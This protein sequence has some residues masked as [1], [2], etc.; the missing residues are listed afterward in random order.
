MYYSISP[1][2]NW[3]SSISPT[4][5]L[6]AHFWIT[7]REYGLFKD[8]VARRD[9]L[10]LLCVPPFVLQSLFVILKTH[11]WERRKI[12]LQHCYQTAA[13]SLFKICLIF[14]VHV[15]ASWPSRILCIANFLWKTCFQDK[16]LQLRAQR[17]P[18]S[19]WKWKACCWGGRPPVL[20]M[21]KF[22]VVLEIQILEEKLVL[23]V[24]EFPKLYDFTKL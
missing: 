17:Q 7:G 5:Q 10:Q 24:C 13:V 18:I 9:T 1:F 16:N 4:I 8:K 3:L 19:H 21:M 12:N 23:A 20:T 6:F 22:T 15:N 14:S 11:G 2:V